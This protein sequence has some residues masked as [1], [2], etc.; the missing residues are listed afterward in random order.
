MKRIISLFV[1]T[2]A[3]LAA[4]TVQAFPNLYFWQT[5]AEA[6]NGGASFLYGTGGATDLGVTCALCHVKGPGLL[7][8]NVTPVPAFG[9]KNGS[10]SYTPGTV[11]SISVTLM[12]ENKG[13]GLGP[14]N[15]NG[16]ALTIENQTGQG[17]GLF[18]N[19]DTAGNMVNTTTCIQ[20]PT[21]PPAA[22]AMLQANLIARG[23]TTYLISPNNT[24]GGGY[25][26]VSVNT[27]NLASW[28]FTW[29]APAAGTGPLTVF[30]GAVDG[31]TG[32]TSSLINDVKQG[33]LKLVE[34][35]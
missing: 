3:L 22:A 4:P 9:Q 29:K 20:V 26:V 27:P 18:T 24:G 2:M 14:K 1:M 30:Y 21:M 31:A 25:T 16:M 17:V 32:G 13:L 8:V 11:Y 28:K 33:T 34:G 12:N 23:A 35:P 19:D 5:A 10:A 6:P 7:G 15:L